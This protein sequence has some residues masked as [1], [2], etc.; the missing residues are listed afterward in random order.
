MSEAVQVIE[1]QALEIFVSSDDCMQF[2]YEIDRQYGCGGAH[3]FDIQP[4]ENI[5]TP[6]PWS[7]ESQTLQVSTPGVYTLQ[8]SVDG[9][10]PSYSRSCPTST[11]ARVTVEACP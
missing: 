8:Y 7:M 6:G 10:A 4:A 9:C 2:T 5:L 11:T 1:P 3:T